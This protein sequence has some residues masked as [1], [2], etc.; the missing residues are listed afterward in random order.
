[1]KRR[2]PKIAIVTP[3]Y[4]PTRAF[5]GP[6]TALYNLVKIFQRRGYDLKVYT[7]D[8]ADPTKPDSQNR[9][10]HH[11]DVDGVTVNRYRAIMSIAGYWITPSLFKDLM[12]D[13]YDIIHAHCARSFQLDLAALVSAMRN[14]PLIATP[15][16]SVYSYGVLGVQ[17]NFHRLAFEMHNAILKLVLRR[18]ARIIATSGEEMSQLTRFGAELRKTRLIPNPLD[19]SEFAHLP[20]IGTFRKRFGVNPSDKL[21]LYVG[22]LA[23]LKGVDTLIRAFAKISERRTNVWLFLVGPDDGYLSTVNRLIHELNCSARVRITGPLYKDTKLEAF[24]DSNL[25]VVPSRY[26]SFGMTALEAFACSKPVI[27]SFVGGLRELIDDAD[28]GFFFP[29]GNADELGLVLDRVLDQR[30]TLER[31][32]KLANDHLHRHY[33]SETIEEEVVGVCDSLFASKGMDS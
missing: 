25:V 27:A 33:S 30:D 15:H 9:L 10:P 13:D 16:G 4:L 12:R 22:R 2:K 23:S 28:T 5:G 21:I 14:K 26:E 18:A 31:V 19:V 29:P 1:M 11:E 3:A 24:V 20:P 17:D 32:G 6:V 8:I 7:T